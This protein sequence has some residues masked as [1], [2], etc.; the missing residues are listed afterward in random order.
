MASLSCYRR[1]MAELLNENGLLVMARGLGLRTILCKFL[2]IHSSAAA[3]GSKKI[4]FVLGLGE[5]ERQLVIDAMVCDGVP[6]GDLPTILD[7]DTDAMTRRSRY[8]A[9]GIF[10]ATDRI[11]VADLM[12]GDR[13]PIASVAGF[14]VAN[15]HEVNDSTSSPHFALRVFFDKGGRGFVKAFSDAPETLTAGFGR[16][17]KTLRALYVAKVW[18]WPR[19]HA[20][21]AAELRC[22]DLTVV[23]ESLALTPLMRTVQGCVLSCMESSLR[24]IASCTALDAEEL[25]L[26]KALFEAFDKTVRRQLEPNWGRVPA[27]AKR[28]VEDLTALRKIL[29]YLT[30]Y[31]A[32][33]LWSFLDHMRA[34]ALAA[35]AAASAAASSRSGGGGSSSAAASGSHSSGDWL[36]SDAGIKLW[37]AVTARLF[38]CVELPVDQSNA[39]AVRQSVLLPRPPQTGKSEA[40]IAALAAGGRAGAGAAGERGAKSRASAFAPAG[41]RVRGSRAPGK[42]KGQ[43]GQT[44]SNVSDNDDDVAEAEEAEDNDSGS[45]AADAAANSI[46]DVD[47]GD[48]VGDG[49]YDDPQDAA[50]A[51]AA[52]IEQLVTGPLIITERRKE[53]VFAV[54]MSTA[55]GGSSAAASSSAPAPASSAARSTDRDPYC[56]PSLVRCRVFR[57]LLRLEGNPKWGALLRLV[58]QYSAAAGASGAGTSLSASALTDDDTEERRLAGTGARILI[59]TRDERAAIQLREL[60][61]ADQD[62]RGPHWSG[63]GTMH[64]DADAAAEEEAL[65][66][67]AAWTG[68]LPGSTSGAGDAGSDDDTALAA[69]ASR[70]MLRQGLCHQLLKQCARTRNLRAAV[71]ASMPRAAP[72]P[73][74]LPRLAALR[75]LLPAEEF[76]LLLASEVPGWLDADPAAVKA[77]SLVVSATVA[78]TTVSAAAPASATGGSSTSSASASGGS[79]GGGSGGGS[80]GAGWDDDAVLAGALGPALQTKVDPAAA[81]AAAAAAAEDAAEHAAVGAGTSAAASASSTGA[82][83]GAG[84]GASA[85][86]AGA[87]AGGDILDVLKRPA[88]AAAGPALLKQGSAAAAPAQPVPQAVV[89]E[90]PLRPAVHPEQRLIWRAA[91][92]LMESERQ[93]MLRQHAFMVASLIQ[94]HGNHDEARHGR[95]HSAPSASSSGAAVAA[96][97]A[98]DSILKEDEGSASDGCGD[99]DS[100]ADADT[101]A[102]VDDASI[103]FLGTQMALASTLP[104]A[105]LQQAQAA[106]QERLARGERLVVPGSEASCRHMRRRPSTS[107]VVADSDSDDAG[108][109]IAIDFPIATAA[110]QSDAPASR[111]AGV[112]DAADD[113]AGTVEGGPAGVDHADGGS[114]GSGGSSAHALSFLVQSSQSMPTQHPSAAQAAANL[115]LRVAAVRPPLPPVPPSSQARSAS[116]PPSSSKSPGAAAGKGRGRGRGKTDSSAASAASAGRGRGRGRG[117]GQSLPGSAVKAGDSVSDAA[118]SAPG[119]GSKLKPEAKRRRVAFADADA[120]EKGNGIGGAKAGD[121]A[122]S[123]DDDDDNDGAIVI[124]DD[125]DAAAAGTAAAA[126]LA[127]TVDE[128]EDDHEP[129]SVAA[130]RAAAA[131][132]RAQNAAGRAALR[133]LQGPL[134]GAKGGASASASSSSL[135]AGAASAAGGAGD[136]TADMLKDALGVHGAHAAALRAQQSKAALALDT[137][138]AAAAAI[139]SFDRVAL[140]GSKRSAAAAGLGGASAGGK[141]GSGDADADASIEFIDVEDGHG[142]GTGNS[143]SPASAAVKAASEP[144]AVV[145]TVGADG[146]LTQQPTAGAGAASGAAVSAGPPGNPLFLRL[147]HLGYR[148]IAVEKAKLMRRTA[149]RGALKGR[150][151]TTM[152]QMLLAAFR[153][154]AAS[155]KQRAAAKE[156]KEKDK[157]RTGG[158][159]ATSAA[160]SSSSASSSAALTSLATTTGVSVDLMHRSTQIVIFPLSRADSRA[161]LLLDVQPSVIVMADPDPVFAREVELYKATLARRRA[162]AVHLLVYG[163]SAEEQRFRSAV[164]LERAAFEKLIAEKATMAPTPAGPVGAGAGAGAPPVVRKGQV[165]GWGITTDGVGGSSAAAI[166]PPGTGAG[167]GAGAGSRGSS[168]AQS[169]SSASWIGQYVTRIRPLTVEIDGEDRGRRLVVVDLREFRARL[170]M[171][172]Y[173][174]G[175]DLAHATL[176]VGDF[177]ISPDMAV[178][179]KSIPDLFGSFASGRLHTQATALC[180]YYARPLLAI[181]FEESKP[182]TL[183]LH[184]GGFGS[185]DSMPPEIDIANP[186][187]K[188]VLLTLHFPKLRLLWCRSSGATARYFAAL[189]QSQ[190]EPN[191][192]IVT[193]YGLEDGGSDD[194]DVNAAATASA[195]GFFPESQSQ[196]AGAGGAAGSGAGTS[197]G[198]ANSSGAWTASRAAAA[199]TGSSI[200]AAAAAIKGGNEAGLDLMRKLPGVGSGNYYRLAMKAGSLA[201]L[202][203]LKRSELVDILGEASAG[204]L[205]NFLHGKHAGAL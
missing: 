174:A 6:R 118:A 175:L 146:L 89:A 156:E 36:R 153:R 92:V 129:G 35:A 7:A 44:K 205:H 187:S 127:V 167:A 41:S 9:G 24:E 109:A 99:A 75:R 20:L 12:S 108:L 200:A 122:G 25:V 42:G 5:E 80:G 11:V 60:L 140:T 30:R 139:A 88:A 27:R 133:Q 15:A 32:V 162:L 45:D 85:P 71:L 149:G 76:E 62:A 143:E 50:D 90:V 158:A 202:A 40:A 70:R 113:A 114:G 46:D 142:D 188:L 110:S 105:E 87:G 1:I 61:R 3:S 53:R 33:Q 84:S 160:S 182:F 136:A 204:L 194:A 197:S 135:M 106:L 98:V 164:R 57:M 190:E 10:L 152:S 173:K 79:S 168:S 78:A 176:T 195:G 4:I 2:R 82:G 132:K 179:R 26:E 170:P 86:D 8:Q 123:D 65:E 192:A 103:D 196:G 19:F 23:E 125:D 172:L 166:V 72:P 126:A 147:G 101:A 39:A 94:P 13:V 116:A 138:A 171:A 64:R 203:A 97:I 148:K 165:D 68:S 124:V 189:K 193:R 150:Q 180:R 28:A 43:A 93:A 107:S 96:T 54:P 21:M 73:D 31:D 177:I 111:G 100:D 59:V 163:V 67:P 115:D 128:D 185:A 181:E 37:R 69:R 186:V 112:D 66:W 117:R 52:I 16:L 157:Q 130:A 77:P 74:D 55:V 184:S 191:P 63:S 201:G 38:E 161:P 18:V 95:Q 29:T 34:A 91:A 198:A 145:A 104:L 131:R 22:P 58:Q 51:D 119:S 141:G 47:D 56:E 81:A 199:A 183:Q 134:P 49:S 151:P 169:S 102:L 155:S 17:E 159:A 154:V 120:D 121:G 137:A 48:G 14:V 83:A 144:D 178:E